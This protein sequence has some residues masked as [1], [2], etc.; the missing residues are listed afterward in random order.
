MNKIDQQKIKQLAIKKLNTKEVKKIR[1]LV[2]QQF[3]GEQRTK[4]I[5]SFNKSFIISFSK[6][7]SKAYQ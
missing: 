7:F 4:C 6:S 1:K 2:C 3:T 5:N